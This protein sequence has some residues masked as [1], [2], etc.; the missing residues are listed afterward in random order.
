MEKSIKSKDGTI[1]LCM[2]DTKKAGRA[3]IKMSA[4][5]IC[6]QGNYSDYNK[7][8][9]HWEEEYC[10]ANKESA[11]GMDYVVSFLDGVDGIPS[12]HGNV[13]YD[14]DGNIIFEDSV[15]VGHVEEVTIEDVE[16]DGVTHRLFTTSGYINT[17]RYPRFYEWLKTEIETG[18][19]CGSIE[20]NGKGGNPK[21]KY[22][23][24]R[25]YNEDGT[26]YMGRTPQIFDFSGLAILCKEIEEPA[27]DLSIV[28]EVNTK[29][30]VTDKT[31]SDNK[32]KKGDSRMNQEQFEKQITELNTQLTGVN[33]KIAELNSVV[34]E[35]DAKIAE[36]NE[37]VV[38]ANKSQEELN[39]KIEAKTK[40]LENCKTEL[41]AYKYKEAQAQAEAKK[42]EV[43]SYMKNEVSKNGFTDSEINSFKELIEACDLEGIKRLE[44]ELC[45]AKFKAEINAK[46]EAESNFKQENKEAEVCSM[47]TIK[48]KE[49]VVIGD[50]M[51]T[52]F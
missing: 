15:S 24:D 4:L 31:V 35:K 7:N 37:V 2:S 46:K 27:D 38:E 20:I 44:S 29:Q 32:T 14:E 13:T 8:G 45:T 12:G 9:L 18:R 49:K 51:P 25:Q 40:E 16:I 26:L 23:D 30:S 28:M 39:S 22:L 41:Q 50:E 52:L 42:A 36:L 48:E 19:V 10:E 17:Q 33:K 3:K 47:F 5:K 11:I 43:N 21:I 6:E 1:E 34:V